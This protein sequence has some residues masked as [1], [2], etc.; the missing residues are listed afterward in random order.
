MTYYNDRLRLK[1]I[2]YFNRNDFSFRSIGVNIFILMVIKVIRQIDYQSRDI[3]I[4]KQ[5]INKLQ[6][7]KV[8]FQAVRIVV[9]CF[10]G[11]M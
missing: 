8:Y 5:L 1:L 6:Y 4:C 7:E 2:S 9:P 3:Y 10:C 11:G